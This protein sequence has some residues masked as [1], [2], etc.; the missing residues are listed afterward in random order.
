[1][2]KVGGKNLGAVRWYLS[3]GSKKSCLR[4]LSIFRSAAKKD[5]WALENEKRERT[6][7]TAGGNQIGAASFKQMPLGTSTEKN[8]KSQLL[9]SSNSFQ[10]LN[11]LSQRDKPCLNQFT[12]SLQYPN[13]LTWSR[14]NLP[15]RSSGLM[16]N[17]VLQW[18]R[19]SWINLNTVIWGKSQTK[20]ILNRE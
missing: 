17:T 12:W 3:R 18:D 20:K 16:G 1:M 14:H 6:A 10:F 9:Q 8:F 4:W 19:F 13:H 2:I 15:N 7:H 11:T 5:K